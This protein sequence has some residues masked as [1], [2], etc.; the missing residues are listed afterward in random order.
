MIVT[1]T[2]PGKLVL[3][4]E[5]AVLEGAPALVMAIDRRA[6]VRL[7]TRTQAPCMLRAPG[8]IAAAVYAGHR[9]AREMDAPIG[10]GFECGT[11]TP[12]PLADS[13]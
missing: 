1:A 2:A 11:L 5:Y 4:G 8:I 12:A 6:E 3:L 9:V 10:T 7:E 13:L